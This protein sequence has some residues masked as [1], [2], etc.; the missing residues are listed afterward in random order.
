M[1]STNYKRLFLRHIAQAALNASIS[2]EAALMAA[3]TAQ[4]TSTQQGLILSTS[5]NNHSVTFAM[6]KSGEGYTQFNLAEMT[7]ELLSLHDVA[8]DSLIAN[9]AVAVP[10]DAQILAEMLGLLVAVR[11]SSADWSSYQRNAYA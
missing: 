10:T 2:L 4:I 3:G 11:D 9:E 5:G 7:E 1:V 8:R 6:P